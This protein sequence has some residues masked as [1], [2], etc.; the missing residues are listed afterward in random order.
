MLGVIC[1]LGLGSLAGC[2]GRKPAERP[3]SV[4]GAQNPAAFDR[5]R[6]IVRAHVAAGRI[7]GAVMVVSHHG[8]L[9]LNEAVGKRDPNSGAAMELDTIFRLASM[10]KPIVSAAALSLVEDGTILLSEAVSKYVPELRDLKVGVERRAANGQ[11]LL[12]LVPTER[13]MTIHDLLRQTSGLTTSFFG[14]SLV[15]SEYKKQGV[16]EHGID[17]KELLARLARVPLQSQP[18]TS[19]EYGRSTDVLG[20]VL[21]RAASQPLDQLLE[22]RILVPL[23]MRDTGFWVD[24]TKRG[25]VAEPFSKDPRTGQPVPPLDVSQRPSFLSGAGGLMSTSQDYLR[26]ASML[27]N[28]GALDRT[29]VLSPHTVRLMTADHTSGRR[30][31]GFFPGEG[32]GFGLGVAVR[33]E[34]G[35]ALPGSVG[36]FGWYGSSGTN[37]WV[38]PAQDLIAVWL[39][40]APGAYE[41]YRRL[42]RTLVYAALDE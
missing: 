37:F 30:G 18:G 20:I 15:K 40:Q 41:Y 27:R 5:L 9:V 17:A 38:D 14:A 12:E 31:A 10:T 1:S 22:Q 19:W 21:E 24:A 39:T 3:K 35:D 32:Y 6:S 11:A 4:A 34:A 8:E 33:I 26:F 28:S 16:D 2:A 36:D 42:Y 25:R 29:R 13:E 23:Q 7:P